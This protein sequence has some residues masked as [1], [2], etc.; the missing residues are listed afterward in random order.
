MK[1]GNKLRDCVTGFEG[2]AVSRIEYLN[3]CVQ[4]C[5]RAPIK[6]GK[7]EDGQWFDVHQLEFVDA[8]IVI[9]RPETGGPTPN[10]RM[11]SGTYGHGAP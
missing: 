9:P 3:G 11:P 6:D 1:L 4:F 7:I 8:G 2:V 5:L 10:G